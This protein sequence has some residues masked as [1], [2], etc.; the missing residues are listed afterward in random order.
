MGNSERRLS[1]SGFM[2][3][4]HTRV[5]FF[6]ADTQLVVMLPFFFPFN[7]YGMSCCECVCVYGGASFKM[8]TKY[9]QH[10]DISGCNSSFKRHSS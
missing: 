2:A 10:I 6:H 8:S 5:K 3:H 9:R 7:E 1:V 4:V